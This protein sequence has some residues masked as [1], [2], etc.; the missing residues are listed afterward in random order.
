LL[1]AKADASALAS[2]LDTNQ[3]S[4]NVGKVMTVGNDGSLTPQAAQGTTYT[5]GQNIAIANNVISA[6]IEVI[7]I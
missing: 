4:A 7:E 1:N 2:K 6:G 3:G 5:A